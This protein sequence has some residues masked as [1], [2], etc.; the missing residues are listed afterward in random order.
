MHGCYEMMM[1]PRRCSRSHSPH[2]IETHVVPRPHMRYWVLLILNPVQ[3]PQILIL[4]P[5][6]LILMRPLLLLLI[7]KILVA[8][9]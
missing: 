6:L 8:G 5:L 2:L 1:I 7:P 9:S 3:F 4:I